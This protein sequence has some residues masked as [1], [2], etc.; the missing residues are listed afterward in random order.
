MS[1]ARLSR[2]ELVGTLARWSVPTVVTIG[3]GRK[4]FAAVPSCPPC[5][6]RSGAR[7]QSCSVSQILN[8]QCEPCLGPPYCTSSS[9]APP[10]FSR[11]PGSSPPAPGAAPGSPPAPGTRLPGVRE[12]R[13]YLLERLRSRQ[14][15]R[16]PF[17][18]PLYRDPFGLDTARARQPSSLYERLN[19]DSRRR[20]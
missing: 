7:C 8:C 1:A 4:V 11:T 14:G 15:P 18:E 17:R 5:T 13:Q 2:R 20:P 9:P 16:D 12:D 10:G 19:Q 3:L 6:K